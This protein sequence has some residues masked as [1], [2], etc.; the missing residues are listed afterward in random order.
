MMPMPELISTMAEAEGVGRRDKTA[1][2]GER[3][4][5]IC[6]GGSYLFYLFAQSVVLRLSY[7]Q[8]IGL[9]PLVVNARSVKNNFSLIQDL[10]QGTNLA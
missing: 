10:V 9:K 2:I 3:H 8:A 1:I 6:T 5:D 4:L 7:C